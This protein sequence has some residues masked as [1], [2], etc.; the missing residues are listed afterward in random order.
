MFIS[1]V[2]IIQSLPFRYISISYEKN[3]SFSVD[4]EPHTLQVLFLPP[5]SEHF[6]KREQKNQM[7]T[8]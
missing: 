8:S 2:V 4:V 7:R 1:V 3:P 5:F 6:T